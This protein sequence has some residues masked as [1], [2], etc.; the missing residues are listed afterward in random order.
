MMRT[1]K[2]LI[3]SAIYIIEYVEKQEPNSDLR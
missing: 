3:K 2:K 1:L